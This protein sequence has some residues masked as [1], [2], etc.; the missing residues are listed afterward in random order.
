MSLIVL[1][2]AEELKGRVA[3]NALW[4]QTCIG[5]AAVWNRGQDLIKQRRKPEIM[6]D[7]AV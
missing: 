3:V 5:I 4:P 2:L 1:G 6:A 7:A